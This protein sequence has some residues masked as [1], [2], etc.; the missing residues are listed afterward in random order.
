M[1]LYEKTKKFLDFQRVVPLLCNPKIGI[2][3]TWEKIVA[4]YNFFSIKSEFILI[5][6]CYEKFY[7]NEGMSV[8]E[9]QIKILKRVENYAK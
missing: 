4:H 9:F 7:L 8:S 6:A 2:L 5:N 3:L 1:G